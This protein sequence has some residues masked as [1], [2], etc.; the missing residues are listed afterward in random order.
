MSI[1]IA[2]IAG[3]GMGQLLGHAGERLNVFTPYGT[4]SYFNLMVDDMEIIFIDRHHSSLGK[5]CL[6]HQLN[7]RA[8]MWALAQAGVKYVIATSAVGGINGPNDI[9]NLAVGSI[10]TPTGFVDLTQRPYTFAG[11]DVL[12]HE[13]AFH[14]S[15]VDMFCPV[16]RDLIARHVIDCP[17]GRLSCVQG[18]R[19]ETLDELKIL[20]DTYHVNFLGMTTAVPEVILAREA[21]M[22]YLLIGNVTNMPFEGPPA[23]GEEV[24]AVVARKAAELVLLIKNLIHILHDAAPDV[25]CQCIKDPSVFEMCGYKF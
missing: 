23:D 13:T 17:S 16:V 4:A 20:R 21:A 9:T 7:H 11:G 22:H 25:K 18:P 12:I 6:P 1:K 2:L 15:P 10:V 24:K 5:F 3:T 19:Y 8:Y 14:R